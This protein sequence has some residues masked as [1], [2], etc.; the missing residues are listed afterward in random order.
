MSTVT[1]WLLISI[2]SS[3]YAGHP[4]SVVERFASMQDC[5]RIAAAL[6]DGVSRP[7]VQC[8]AATVLACKP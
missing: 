7:H 1:V 3:N 4:H 6:N 8:L 5:V 2:G